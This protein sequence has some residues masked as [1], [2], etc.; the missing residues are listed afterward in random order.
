MER[1]VE[2]GG[3]R[4]E[5][6]NV[7]VNKGDNVQV[8]R[9]RIIDVLIVAKITYRNWI[10]LSTR[11][12]QKLAGIDS[13][14]DGVSLTS[15]KQ[16]YIESKSQSRATVN[17]FGTVYPGNSTLFRTSGGTKMLAIMSRF[18]GRVMKRCLKIV[19]HRRRLTFLLHFWI[20][21]KRCRG[22]E[23]ARR[24]VCQTRWQSAPDKNPPCRTTF[25]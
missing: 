12:D 18:T 3:I 17:D 20:R 14:R 9:I 21:R 13:K 4:R 25:P 23:Y 22:W 1:I 24:G 5:R 2:S 19:I 16:W 6:L 11:L 15:F 10:K 8:G 7:L